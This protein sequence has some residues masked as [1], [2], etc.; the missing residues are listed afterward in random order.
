MHA[1]DALTPS[2]CWALVTTQSTGRLRFFRDGLLEIFP[3]NY[4][5]LDERVYVRTRADG[6][7][8]TSH[9]EHAA[10]QTHSTDRTTQSG[11]TVL[12]NGPAARVEDPELLTTLWGTAAEEPWAPGLR[13]LFFALTP[14]H[15]RGRRLHTTH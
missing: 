2:Q 1:S 15:V 9:L 5:V 14:A 7:I 12:V 10:V 8:A 13:D 3:V 4:F 11:W 6:I